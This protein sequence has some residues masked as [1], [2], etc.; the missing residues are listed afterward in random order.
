MSNAS[1]QCSPRRALHWAKR[2]GHLPPADRKRIF[3]KARALRRAAARPL[4]P[5]ELG[6]RNVKYNGWTYVVL[7]R[8]HGWLTVLGRGG[9]FTFKCRESALV[10]QRPAK[11]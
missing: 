9:K 8:H 11:A 4:T 1:S 6:R 10:N 7:A 5:G 2:F 3:L